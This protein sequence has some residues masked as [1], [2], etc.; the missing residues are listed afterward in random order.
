[1]QTSLRPYATAGIALVGAGLIATTPAAPPPPLQVRAVQLASGETGYVVNSPNDLVGLVVGGTGSPIPSDAYVDTAN[2]LYIQRILPGATSVGVF[3]PEGGS[4]IYTGVKSLPF[5]TSFAQGTKMLDT[6][7]E[8]NV[9]AGNTVAVSGVSQS[10]TISGFVMSDLVKD[11]IPADKVKFFLVGD[12][13]NPDGGL[14][15][16]FNFPVVGGGHPTLP[17]LQITFSGAT[18]PDTPYDTSIYSLEYDGFAD[19]PKYPINF[20]ADLNAFLG[21]QSVHPLYNTLTKA[22]YDNAIPVHTTSDYHGVTDY[23]M[24]PHSAPLVD[25]VGKLFGKPVEDLVGPDL[26]VLINMGYDNP[27]P[28]QG[29]DVGQANVPT[30][31]GLFPSASQMMAD[32]EALGPATQQ[33]IQAF[34]AD[35]SHPSTAA[36]PSLFTDL[37]SGGT[38]SSTDPASFTDIVN[39]FTAAFSKAYS[40]LLPTAD[41]ITA[42]TQQLPVYDASLFADNILT[43]PLDAFGLPIA[44]NTGLLTLAAGIEFMVIE[45]SVRSIMSDLSGL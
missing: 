39:A 30:A 27:D 23:Y 44:A 34:M 15:E 16:R 36:S 4:P 42:L 32:L 38:A 10:S 2:E 45:E 37:L 17:S 28:S 8:N 21:I 1:V 9:A 24:I 22:D 35:M 43:N 20:L 19:F 25:L 11:G 29:W 7:I 26:T 33:G 6:Y 40:I 13:S 31:F 14:L 5:D 18:P 41:I 3:T 12:P